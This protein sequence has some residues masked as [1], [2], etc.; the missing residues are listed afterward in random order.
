[1]QS[2][3]GTYLFVTGNR[4]DKFKHDI[5]GNSKT[6]PTFDEGVGIFLLGLGRGF[7]LL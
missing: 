3:L 7:V 4:Y 5:V 2:I 1:M 6:Q